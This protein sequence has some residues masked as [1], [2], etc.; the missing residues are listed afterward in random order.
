M[1]ITITQSELLELLKNVKG[2]TFATITS[3]TE[4]A[5]K[6]ESPFK[7]SLEKLS[8]VNICL[9]F[10]YSNS[11]RNQEIREGMEGDF[12]AKPRKWGQ[13]IAGTPLVE[14]K[15]KFY[16][17][18]K[19]ERSMGQLYLNNNKIINKNEINPF[20]KELTK[21]ATQ[22]HLEKIVI[23]RDYSLENIKRI[24]IGKNVYNIQ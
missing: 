10:H 13:R 12:Q 6:K 19:I 16:L 18:A 7:H 21:P 23:L 5:Q 9:G 15:G 3:R 14:H 4:P 2:N 11:V 22:E 8:R 20:L 17:E 1:K 24:R